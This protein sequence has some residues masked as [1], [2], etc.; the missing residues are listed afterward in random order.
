VLGI[1][2]VVQFAPPFAVYEELVELARKAKTREEFPA[3]VVVLPEVGKVLAVQ[4]IPSVLVAASL[5][6]PLTTAKKMPF[7]YPAAYHDF[8]LGIV[9]DVQEVPFVE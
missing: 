1:V 8:E 5:E 7:P 4:V 9:I 3:T 2:I 6:V